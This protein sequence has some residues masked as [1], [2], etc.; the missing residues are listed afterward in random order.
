MM[1]IVVTL[2]FRGPTDMKLTSVLA[3]AIGLGVYV[4]GIAVFGFGA[5]FRGLPECNK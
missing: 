5:M 1:G 2:V 3:Q 4:N